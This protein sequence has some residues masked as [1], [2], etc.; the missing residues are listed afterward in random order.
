MTY[1]QLATKHTKKIRP[2]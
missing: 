2:R 1:V